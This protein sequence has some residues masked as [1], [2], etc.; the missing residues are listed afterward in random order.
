MGRVVV[1]S[2]VVLSEGTE[3]IPVVVELVASADGPDV[4]IIGT[5]LIVAVIG[6][7]REGIAVE[8]TVSSANAELARSIV[9]LDTLIVCNAFLLKVIVFLRIIV[10]TIDMVICI[11]KVPTASLER[12][13][14]VLAERYLSAGDRQRSTAASCRV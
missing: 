6:N 11:F 12:S 3:D 5:I 2:F 7:L 13:L 9:E 10:V 14:E 4:G 1:V 8:V